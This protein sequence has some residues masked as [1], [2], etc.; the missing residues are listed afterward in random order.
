MRE[1]G[2]RDQ[3]IMESMDALRA[4]MALTESF[5]HKGPAYVRDVSEWL[6][7]LKSALE[8]LE[9]GLSK[10]WLD[11]VV[12]IESDGVN[13]LDATLDATPD[14]DAAD[15]DVIDIVAQR[16]LRFW[17][18]EIKRRG[19]ELVDICIV[20]VDVAE[21]KELFGVVRTMRYPIK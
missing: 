6:A 1:A 20:S 4:V 8:E 14:L 2:I 17:I 21:A 10:G 9:E 18:E 3:A 5:I 13:S 11:G 12:T 15:D 19:R 7:Q 16:C